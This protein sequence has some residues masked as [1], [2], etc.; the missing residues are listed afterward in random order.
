MDPLDQTI[1]LSAFAMPHVTSFGV[2][3]HS[4]IAQHSLEFKAV[5]IEPSKYSD[6]SMH[7]VPTMKRT[8]EQMAL[9]ELLNEFS[10]SDTAPLSVSPSNPTVTAAKGSNVPISQ[11]QQPAVVNDQGFN[12]QPLPLQKTDI[13]EQIVSKNAQGEYLDV[14]PFIRYS[15]E[16]AARKLGIPSSTLSKRWRE[17]TMNRKWPFRTLCKLEREIKTLVHNLPRGAPIDPDVANTLAV[18]LKKRE[19]ECRQV[20]IKKSTLK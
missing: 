12:L 10:A 18:L 8:T 6:I 14:T 3:P 1:D 13:I 4:F 5:Q 2:G 7:T 15:Q 16:D 9:E 20:F 17:S 19:E 11:T